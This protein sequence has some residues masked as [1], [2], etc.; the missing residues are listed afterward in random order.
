MWVL[1]LVLF[2]LK[3]WAYYSEKNTNVFCV[4][5]FF[6]ICQGIFKICGNDKCVH[7]LKHS[8]NFDFNNQSVGNYFGVAINIL[9]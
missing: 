1:V 6:S 2:L 8:P 5:Y 9:L 7:P 3:Y 4:F